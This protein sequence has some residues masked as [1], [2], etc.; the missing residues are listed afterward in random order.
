[1]EDE[2]TDYGD[3]LN[4]IHITVRECADLHCP[5]CRK[6]GTVHTPRALEAWIAR[7]K[8]CIEVER[9]A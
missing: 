9:G 3:T 6:S 8:P 4:G 7:H 2:L 5:G 1:M